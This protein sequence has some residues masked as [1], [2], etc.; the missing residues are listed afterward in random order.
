VVLDTCVDNLILAIHP[1]QPRYLPG[2]IQSDLPPGIAF[3]FDLIYTF[4]SSEERGN[5]RRTDVFTYVKPALSLT[6][7][8]KVPF[9]DIFALLQCGLA[10]HEARGDF[11]Q[12]LQ[13]WMPLELIKCWSWLLSDQQAGTLTGLCLF[14]RQHRGN[15]IHHALRKI[16]KSSWRPL[17]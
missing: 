17:L 9:D 13:Q 12:E 6:A 7:R 15:S 4:D 14:L 16:I 3:C 8:E 11:L 1:Y 5:R 10:Q 2:E